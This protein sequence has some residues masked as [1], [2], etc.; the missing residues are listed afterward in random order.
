[1]ESQHPQGKF[2]KKI[3]E[4]IISEMDAT[5]GLWDVSLSCGNFGSSG[6]I[7]TDA[8]HIKKGYDRETL[9]LFRIH[10]SLCDGV[11][12]AVAI[13]DLADEAAHLR[14]DVVKNMLKMERNKNQNRASYFKKKK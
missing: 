4:S 9:A 3:E 7:S 13:G 2:A 1:M 11:S 12:I 14:E 5:K 6:A 8:N 10:H